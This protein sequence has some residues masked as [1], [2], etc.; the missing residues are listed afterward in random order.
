MSDPDREV[1]D[2]DGLPRK[3]GELVFEAPWQGRAF[4]MAAVLRNERGLE[5]DARGARARAARSRRPHQTGDRPAAGRISDDGAAGRLLRRGPRAEA[6]RPFLQECSNSL[7]VVLAQGSRPADVLRSAPCGL[8]RGI[9]RGP[10]GELGCS[11]RQ[12]A[13]KRELI[14]VHADEPLERLRRC[15]PVHETKSQRFSRRD[16]SR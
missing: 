13:V 6:R 7:G 14:G 4:G 8:V 15:E 12:R 9:L 1:A 2:L 10:D 16:D 5:W 11:D 3:N